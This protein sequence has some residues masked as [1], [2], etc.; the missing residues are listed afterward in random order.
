MPVEA[1]S[2]ICLYEWMQYVAKM[3]RTHLLLTWLCNLTQLEFFSCQM[4]EL[5]LVQFF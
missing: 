3:T 5:S 2:V 1:Y 4:H